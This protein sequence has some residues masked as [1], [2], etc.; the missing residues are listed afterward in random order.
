M[1][2]AFVH[3]TKWRNKVEVTRSRFLFDVEPRHWVIGSH[4]TSRKFHLNCSTGFDK[5]SGSELHTRNS[6]AHCRNLS[7]IT[8]YNVAYLLTPWSR[9][10]LE[11]LTGPAASQEI[12][13]IFGTRRFITVLRSARH[14][15]LSWANSI[16]SSQPPPTS[17]IS[18]LILSNLRLGL[19]SGHRHSTR[20]VTL[21][22]VRANIVAAQNQ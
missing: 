21:R 16:Q 15:S 2:Q 5:I 12:P 19:P 17:W 18:I 4:Q 14:L 8:T 10:L 11:K 6:L 9:V 13:R 1:R 7:I 3:T 20:H 22:C